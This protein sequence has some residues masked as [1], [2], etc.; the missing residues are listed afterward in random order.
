MDT[1]ESGGIFRGSVPFGNG[2][3]GSSSLDTLLAE[4]ECWTVNHGGSSF[5]DG[6]SEE[7]TDGTSLFSLQVYFSGAWQRRIAILA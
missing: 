1:S 3:G 2:K 6:T 5:E 4:F 7:A